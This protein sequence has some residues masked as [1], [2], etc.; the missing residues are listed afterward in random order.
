MLLVVDP[1]ETFL[2][3]PAN[4]GGARFLQSHPRTPQ[5]LHDSPLFQYG[6][7][8]SCG[9]GPSALRPSYSYFAADLSAAYSQKITS[10]TRSF[11]FLN[12][13]S[14]TIPHA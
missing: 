12:L 2:K 10:F 11:C 1:N 4:D 13:G 9:F 5:Q 6:R 14:P 7:R 3:T 8:L